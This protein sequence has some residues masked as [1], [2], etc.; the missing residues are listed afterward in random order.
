MNQSKFLDLLKLNSRGGHNQPVQNYI[1]Q[2]LEEVH[3]KFDIFDKTTIYNIDDVSLP[4]FA[5]HTDTVRNVEDDIAADTG[6]I[7]VIT[8][9][10]NTFIINPGCVLGGDDMCGV[11]IILEMLRAGEKFNFV[12]TDGEETM[13]GSAEP[14]VRVNT[15]VLSKMPYGIILDRKGNS[16]IICTHNHY[17]SEKFENQ[18]AKIGEPFGY[19]PDTGMCSDADFIRNVM[20]CANLSIGYERAHSKKEYV[21]WENMENCYDYSVAILKQLKDATRFDVNSVIFTLYFENAI[22]GNITSLVRA[23][24]VLGYR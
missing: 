24:G 11:H 14:F 23:S 9:K 19:S 22:L 13:N 8:R 10:D 7:Q 16:D 3:V 1:K 20:S 6:N 4:L 18:L 5:A 15:E 21:V 12:F 2:Q 17:G